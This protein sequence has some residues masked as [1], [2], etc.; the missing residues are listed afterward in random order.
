MAELAHRLD[1]APRAVEAHLHAAGQRA[2]ETPGDVAEV[3]G[4]RRW[5]LAIPG[6][7]VQAMWGGAE[8]KSDRFEH[9]PSRMLQDFLNPRRNHQRDFPALDSE[10][11]VALRSL[12]IDF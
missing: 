2:D 10:N 5:G 7:R 4:V 12:K 6:G 9:R 1:V 3:S 8:P 11:V